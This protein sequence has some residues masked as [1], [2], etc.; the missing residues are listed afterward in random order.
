MTP[1]YGIPIED[2]RVDLNSTT[3]D[4]NKGEVHAFDVE[5]V[6]EGLLD[7]NTS[8]AHHTC[9]GEVYAVAGVEGAGFRPADLHDLVVLHF[10]AFDWHEEDEP[11]F[12]HPRDP[13]SRID[14]RQSSRHVRVELDGTC[15]PTRLVR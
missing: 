4:A 10:D 8:F 6:G 5:G 15:W 14:M 7:P 3:A 1:S 11:I 2:I 13:F 9:P 12:G